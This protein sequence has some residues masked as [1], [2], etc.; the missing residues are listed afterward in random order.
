MEKKFTTQKLVYFALFAAFLC[1]CAYISIPLPLPGAPHITLVNF[2]VILIGLLFAPLDSFM[3]VLVYV[4]LG[5]VGVPV[6]IGGKGGA[7]YLLQ[8]YGAYTWAFLIA[9][10]ALPFIRGKKYNV[11]RYIVAA[12]AGVL[13]IDIVGM[14]YLMAVSNYDLK[15][16]I[17]TGFV[18]FIPLDIV[19]AVVAALI[20]PAFKRVMKQ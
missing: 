10:I 18:P 15:T 20:V 14:L 2:T 9:A 12:I 4:L 11:A 16:G 17:M 19:K 3:I 13:I 7:A 6:F 5:C 1:V 8:P